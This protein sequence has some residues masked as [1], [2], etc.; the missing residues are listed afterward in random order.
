MSHPHWASNTEPQ[1]PHSDY[2]LVRGDGVTERVSG[3]GVVL[4]N[5]DQY[6]VHADPNGEDEPLRTVPATEVVAVYLA[7]PLPA[8]TE[9]IVNAQTALDAAAAKNQVTETLTPPK[10]D[11]GALGDIWFQRNGAGVILGAW[12]WQGNPP[13]W[14]ERQFGSSI[15]NVGGG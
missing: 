1:V 8:P 12:A 14:Q 11:G 6:E 2:L 7:P 9:P 13:A 3:V 5:G 4:L 10:G 15:L